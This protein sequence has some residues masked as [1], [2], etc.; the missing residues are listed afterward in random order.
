M[1]TVTEEAPV[2][3]QEMTIHIE[4][5]RTP[6]VRDEY[7]ELSGLSDS[8]EA[9]G[10]RH[11]ITL[12]ADG[13]LISGARRLRA[14]FLLSG[15]VQPGKRKDFRHI[16]AV[17]VDTIEDAAKR[18]LNDNG[19]DTAAIPLKPSQMCKLWAVMR[20]LDEPA[21]VRRVNE[22]RR[23]GVELRRQTLTGKRTPGRSAAQ[24][25]G[26]DYFL[27]VLGEP[28]GMSE[29]TAS[30]L[31]AIHK[32][33]TNPV[34]PDERRSHAASCLAAID[35]GDSSIYANYA[36]L[37][38]N[39]STPVSR[40]RVVAPIE[41]APAPR[42]RAAWERS[43]PQLE[44]LIAGLSELGP[45]NS[46]LSWDQVGPVHARLKKIRRDMEKIINN[47]KETAQS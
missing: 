7:G 31:W 2:K 35:N 16:P 46:E 21:A 13:T 44:G 6:Q 1:N 8:I 45:P 41:S 12:W 36:A 4:T 26:D 25:R 30:R 15:R 43:L 17:F 20:V 14:H 37:L 33:A 3:G 42:Q 39:R 32:V 22:A 47:M 23:R 40:V 18:L 5:V 38:S 24:G 27:A 10:L 19:D 29:A 34:L 28:F 11:P 9:D